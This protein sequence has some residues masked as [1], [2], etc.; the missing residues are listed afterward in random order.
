MSLSP[1]QAAEFVR[2]R[3]PNAGLFAGMEWRISPEPFRI[4]KRL[5]AEFEK[6]GRVLLQFNRAVNQLYRKSAA[7][8]AP[9]WVA[10]YLD[11]G[12]PRQIVEWQQSPSFKNDV[13]R[14][15]RPDILLT[16]DGFRFLNSIASPAESG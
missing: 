7:G 16:E 10:E 1:Q 8:N 15:I 5:L 3:I 6:L 11:R 13:P 12:K 14:V 9:A 4:E 2:A